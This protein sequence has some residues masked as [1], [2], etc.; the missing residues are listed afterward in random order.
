M[1]LMSSQGMMDRLKTFYNIQSIQVPFIQSRH[2]TGEAS[3]YIMVAVLITVLCV[4]Q[5]YQFTTV[6]MDEGTVKTI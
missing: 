4:E 3:W 5:P 6:C 2:L 1:L